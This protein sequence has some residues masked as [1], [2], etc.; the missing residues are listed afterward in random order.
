MKIHYLS[1][2]HLEFI[3]L[4]KLD[5][6]IK[7]IEP[8]LDG[9]CILAG[10]IGNLFTGN[11]HYDIF[12]EYINKCFKKIFVIAGNHE[13]YSDNKT[14]IE[15]NIDLDTYFQ[16]FQNITFLNNRCE[17]YD[18][19]Y[20]IGT[21]LWSHVNNPN[22]KINDSFQIKNFN[23]E[24][25]NLLNKKC[26]EFLE[27]NLQDNSIII[28]HHVPSYSLI[29]AKYKTTSME[30]YNQWFYSDMDSFIDKYKS[31]IKLW[32]Y[33]HTH[34]PSVK[35]IHDIPFVCNPIGYPG[36]NLTPNF[37]KTISLF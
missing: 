20:F 3:K 31:K 14:I 21:T 25:C 15:S 18:N 5:Q 17:L 30:P 6:F 11:N 7:N 16:K 19:Y 34:T 23:S 26:I 4:N 12:M 29:D 8:D 27:N 33:G 36:E 13:Y 24:M 1:D 9:I 37:N 35:F 10:D 2:L 32:V 28:T 22:Y